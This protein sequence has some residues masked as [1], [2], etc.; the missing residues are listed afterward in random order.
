MAKE[1]VKF[2]EGA[3]SLHQILEKK[4]NEIFD[5][6]ERFAEYG[7]NRSHAAAY[8][9][10]AYQTAYLKAHYPAEYM[11]AVM[12]RKTSDVS[13]I[14][15]LTN[16]CKRMGIDVLGPNV[17]E[18][19]KFFSVNAQGKIRFALSAIK[20]LGEA[21]VE[22]IVDERE[23]KG[24]YVSFYD[25]MQRVNLRTVNKKSLEALTLAGAL[26]DFNNGHRAQYLHIGKDGSLFIESVAKWAGSMVDRK[27][28][29]VASLFGNSGADQTLKEPPFPECERWNMLQQLK[30]EKEVTGFY[31]SGHPL[32]AYKLDMETFANCTLDKV[33][34]GKDKALT[35]AGIVVSVDTRVDKNGNKFARFVLEDF[36]G[37]LDLVVFNEDYIKFNQY[38]EAGKM[39]YIK[40]N[41]QVRFRNS[42]NYEFKIKSIQLLSTVRETE[43]RF[44]HVKLSMYKVDERLIEQINKV[45]LAHPGKCQFKMTLT[46]EE[47][48]T[49]VNLKSLDLKVDSANEFI[50]A[51]NELDLVSVKLGAG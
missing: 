10:L 9:V 5:I 29:S 6:M 17:N 4:S 35:I 11:A 14:S 25:M 37:T 8:S 47:E 49:F 20:G 41:Y 15:F 44:V 2:V 32:D 43:A 12:S 26:D 39:L 30:H 24:A 19:Q 18:S 13:T 1:R 46:D 40:G 51:L 21:A 38:L 48:N 36:T 50:D 31:L 34:Q 27:A 42:E 16:E 22:A 7:F 28:S 33:T 3:L 45:C 23:A